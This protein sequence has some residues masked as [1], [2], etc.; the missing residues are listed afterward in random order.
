MSAF[1]ISSRKKPDALMMMC[2]GKYHYGYT[3]LAVATLGKCFTSLGQSSCI[4]TVI[5]DA[6][7]SIDI[8]RTV[9]SGL[10]LAATTTSACLLPLTGKLID[11]FG[12]RV[13]VVVY[14]LSL[15]LGCFVMS[16]ANSIIH[17]FLALFML[18]F[19][20]QGTYGYVFYQQNTSRPHP[21]HILTLFIYIYRIIPLIHPSSIYIYQP[22]LYIALSVC[23]C[24]CVS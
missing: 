18:R 8:S 21:Q 12:P 9:M 2:S 11:R 14:A 13:M 15:G 1:S 20:G 6:R 24:V 16:T 22:C 10:Y 3:V 17:L 7:V 5:E 23:V 19:F 4:G